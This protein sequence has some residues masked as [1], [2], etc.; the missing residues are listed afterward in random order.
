MNSASF[1]P[2]LLRDHV[3]LNVRLTCA[4]FWYEIDTVVAELGRD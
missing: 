2:I 4:E 1:I 3:R